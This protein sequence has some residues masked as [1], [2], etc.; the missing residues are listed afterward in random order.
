M[1]MPLYAPLY[2]L[3][4]KCPGLRQLSV[5]CETKEERI[6]EVLERTPF[7][8]VTNKFEINV[9]D[10]S[11]HTLGSFFESAIH[12]PAKFKDFTGPYMAYFYIDRRSPQVDAAIC[13]AREMFGYPKKAAIVEYVERGDYVGG[14]VERGGVKIMELSCELSEE[15]EVE[16]PPSLSAPINLLMKVIPSCEKDGKPL[17][18]VIVR[19][20]STSA[21][22]Y[23]M[24]RFGKASVKLS[25]LDSDPIYRLSPTKVL[26]G[27]FTVGDF[28]GA[29]G[30]VLATL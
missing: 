19:P 5:I 14:T 24:K 29:Y 8:F 23:K 22:T 16:V 30:K 25:R 3:E 26:G 12:I 11:N 28:I 18:Q 21:L 10:L 2:P 13:A 1:S 20:C 17:K 6:R 7:E 9:A 4:W 15:E 27:I